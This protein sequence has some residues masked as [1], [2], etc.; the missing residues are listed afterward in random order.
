MSQIA[1]TFFHRSRFLEGVDHLCPAILAVV[2]I[3][4]RADRGEGGGEGLQQQLDETFTALRAEG[5]SKPVVGPMSFQVAP[6]MPTMSRRG[7]DT[8]RTP[9]GRRATGASGAGGPARLAPP[10]P[11]GGARGKTAPP[12]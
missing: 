11:R 9:P 4:R 10:P 2:D 1:Q 3:R 5:W 7:R 12:P 6:S 8:I